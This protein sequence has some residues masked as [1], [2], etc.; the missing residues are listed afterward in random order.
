MQKET[1]TMKVMVTPREHI[2]PEITADQMQRLR[3]AGATEVVVAH[4]HETRVREIRDCDALI[5][6]IDED[7]L[8]HAGQLRWMQSLSSGVDMFLFPA[9]VE[10]DI[11]L[12]SEKGLV[13]EHLADHAFGLLL[14][15]TRSIAWAT[16]LRRWDHRLDMRLVN[17]ELTGMTAGLIGLGGTGVAV[18]KRAHAFGMTCLAIDPDVSTAPDGVELLGGPENLIDMAGRSDVIFVCCP[19]TSETVG[20]VNADVIAA[21]PPGGYL[22]NVTRGGIVDEIALL[23]AIESGHLTGAGLDVT[24]EE[25]LPADSP[26]WEHNRIIITP[27]TAGAS[28]HRVGRIIDRVITNLQHLTNGEPLEGVIDKRKGY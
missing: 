20:M 28:Q 18:A 13:G 8:E 16:R 15:L 10:S 3:A 17:R 1:A 21:M 24:A 12:T 2:W 5:G 27:H 23:N 14:S 4:D 11:V 25:P 7:M 22:I 9:F 6:I 19:K 26:L